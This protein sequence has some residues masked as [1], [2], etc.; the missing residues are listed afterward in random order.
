MAKLLGSAM[1]RV[2]GAFGRAIKKAGCSI[3][4]SPIGLFVDKL[5][6]GSSFHS[7]N[8]ALFAAWKDRC[9]SVQFSLTGRHGVNG[10][11]LPASGYVILQPIPNSNRFINPAAQAL[12]A[13]PKF[14]GW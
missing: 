8:P 6:P 3:D 12:F 13:I 14:S 9:C 11:C 1:A 10:K 4:C 5:K 7:G 2:I